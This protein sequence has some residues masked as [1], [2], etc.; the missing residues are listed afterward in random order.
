ML[1]TALRSFIVQIAKDR[2]TALSALALVANNIEKE[3]Q[4]EME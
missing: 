1:S 2:T 3:I 4:E